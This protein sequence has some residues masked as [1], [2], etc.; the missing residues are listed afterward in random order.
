M[1]PSVA[2]VLKRGSIDEYPKNI[3]MFLVVQL[4][5]VLV[6]LILHNS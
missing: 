1:L 5:D 4:D 6:V 2:D 3:D